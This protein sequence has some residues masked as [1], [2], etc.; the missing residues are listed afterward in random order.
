LDTVVAGVKVKS[1]KLE[2]DESFTDAD[3]DCDEDVEVD[4]AVTGEGCSM[5]KHRSVKLLLDDAATLPWALGVGPD[6]GCVLSASVQA[7]SLSLAFKGV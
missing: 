7:T 2:E 3:E 6:A 5:G 1:G 4:E